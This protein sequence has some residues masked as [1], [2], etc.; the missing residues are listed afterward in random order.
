MIIRS[1]YCIQYID[2]YIGVT[3]MSLHINLSAI[4]NSE[5][6]VDKILNLLKMIFV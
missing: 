2:I 3:E 4:K 1:S 6:S 5:F